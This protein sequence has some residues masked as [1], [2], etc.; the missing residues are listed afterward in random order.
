MRNAIGGVSNDVLSKSVLYNGQ[1]SIEILPV[2][3]SGNTY[4]ECDGPWIPI[5]PGDQIVFSVWIKTSA[6]TLGDTSIFAGGAFGIDI[7]SNSGRICGLN[8]PS[9]QEDWT[10]SGGFPTNSYMNYVVWGTSTW[11]LRTM[12][13]TVPTTY[14][15]DQCNG[16]G[17]Y[18][19]GT[20]VVPTGMLPVLTVYS[21]VY[22]YA[23]GGDAWFANIQV[24]VTP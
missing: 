10:P 2:G 5:A 9:G 17:G 24:T 18:S 6:S 7:Y 15:A 20:A 22:G 14:I 4:R 3:N 1:D 16:G 19:A 13:F 23:D 8:T 21:N 11:T 12:T